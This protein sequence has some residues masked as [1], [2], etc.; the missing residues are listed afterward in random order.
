MGLAV[1]LWEQR[2]EMVM[3]G[4]LLLFAGAL[5]FFVGFVASLDEKKL[6]KSN[7]VMAVSVI[8]MVIGFGLLVGAW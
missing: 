7:I 3:T 1:L 5:A 8:V 2:E 6:G 4:A